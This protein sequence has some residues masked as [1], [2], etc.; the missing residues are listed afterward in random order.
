[1]SYIGNQPFNAS[2]VTDSFSGT[3]S[4]TVYTLTI[5]PGSGNAILVVISGVLQPPSTYSVVGQILTFSSPPPVGTNNIVVRYLSLPASSVT[6][7]AFR[8]ISEFTATSGQ[9]TFIPASYSPGF[10]EVFRNG[11]RLN[12]TDFTA[13]NGTTVVLNNS[14]YGGDAI[15]IVGFYISSVLNGIVNGPASISVSNLDVTAQG[16]TGALQLPSG[17]TGQRP[18]SPNYG[19]QR[20]NS[21]INAM[22]VYLTSNTWQTITPTSLSVSYLIV[23][24]GGGGGGAGGGGGGGVLASANLVLSAGTTYPIVVGAAGTGAQSSVRGGNGGNSSFNGLTAIGGGG[25]GNYGGSDTDG[26]AGGS[27]GGAGHNTGSTTLGGSG[28]TGQGFK[29][30]D[31]PIFYGNNPYSSGGGGGGGAVGG[32]VIANNV[33]GAGGIGLLNSITG[34]NLYWAGGG[35]GGQ[36]GSGT[37]GN[38]GLGGGGGGCGYWSGQGTNGTGGGSA[39]NSG[40]AGFGNGSS[41]S[42]GGSGGTNTGGGGGGMAI[43]VNYG[44]P[45]GSGVVIISYVG[46]NLRASGGVVTQSGNTII[47]SFYSSG[48][49]ITY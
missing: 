28:T 41:T 5:G 21:S 40:T 18:S 42:T 17:S 48:N 8:N 31:K 1:M 12:S 30:G 25:G 4:Q 6:N 13:T 2:F 29:G 19:M 15:T 32:N 22:E 27:G 39:L 43:S 14:A 44:G 24:G 37:A 35:G 34:S 38:G 36:Q 9:T 3:G 7:T 45:G 10:V 47:H 16:G 11:A 33:S 26:A 46:Q 20:W 49:F 23:A